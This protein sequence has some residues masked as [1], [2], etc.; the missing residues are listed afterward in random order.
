[1]KISKEDQKTITNVG[2]IIGGLIVAKM[3][4]DKFMKKDKV[5]LPVVKEPVEEIKPIDNPVTV[6][7]TG[8]CFQCPE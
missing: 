3:L 5:V 2:V 1:M 6:P 8:N 7:G 4:F